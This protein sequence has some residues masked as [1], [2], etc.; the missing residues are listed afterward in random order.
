MAKKLVQLKKSYYNYLDKKAKHIAFNFSEGR[1]ITNLLLDYISE[2]Y[3]SAKVEKDFTN[4]KFESAY[5]PSVT[6][7][8]E[9]LIAR[10]LYHYSDIKNLDWKIYLRKQFQKTAP[11]IRIERNKK[12]IAIIEIKAKA[13]WMQSFFSKEREIKDTKRL[14]NGEIDH[15]PQKLIE[16]MR[17]QLI[18]YITTYKIN[19][20]QIF[21]FLPTL[22]CVHRKGSKRTLKDYENDFVKNSKLKKENFILLSK[23]L[24]LDLSPECKRKNYQP[25]NNF[26]EFINKTSKASHAHQI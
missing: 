3:D 9:F 16:D 13:G 25:T 1:K 4:K 15:G 7:E 19:K 2:L 26:E 6:P 10:I 22:I 8:L 23:N 24:I 21:V 12:T 17:N 18:K 5:H 14:E 11:D 20:G